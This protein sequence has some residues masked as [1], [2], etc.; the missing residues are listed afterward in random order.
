[1]CEICTP[2]AV[3]GISLTRSNN[4]ADPSASVLARR[5]FLISLPSWLSQLPKLQTLLVDDNPFAGQ[6]K[7][8]VK[9][10]ASNV[11]EIIPPVPQIPERFAARQPSTID[12]SIHHRRVSGSG[13]ANLI[14]DTSAAPSTTSLSS[15]AENVMERSYCQSSPSAAGSPDVARSPYGGLS[16]STSTYFSQTSHAEDSTVASPASQ[17]DVAFFDS[18]LNAGQ[19]FWASAAPPAVRSADSIVKDDIETRKALSSVRAPP[20]ETTSR[21]G[22]ADIGTSSKVVRRMRS[23]GTLFG[24][25][26]ESQE[27]IARQIINEPQSD[28]DEDFQPPQPRFAT[29]SGRPRS[30]A[31]TSLVSY[32]TNQLTDYDSSKAGSSTSVA[33]LGTQRSVSDGKAPAQN[34]SGKWG[35]LKK[36]SMSRLRAN[37]SSSTNSARP[38]APAHSLSES[39]TDSM[40]M[41]PRMGHASYSTGTLSTLGAE[42]PTGR[43]LYGGVGRNQHPGRSNLRLQTTLT[44]VQ[45][46]PPHPTVRG[47][48]QSFLPIWDPPPALNIPIPSTSPFMSS[49]PI[50][51][52]E[53]RGQQLD[54]SST[55]EILASADQMRNS[56][57]VIGS[58]EFGRA[59]PAPQRTVPYDVGLR[60]IM[61]YLRDLYDLSLPVPAAIGGAEVVAAEAGTGSGSVSAGSDVRAESPSPMVGQ[62]GRYNTFVPS[63]RSKK[64][65]FGGSE[66]PRE[67]SENSMAPASG[68][69]PANTAITKMEEE[70]D[71]GTVERPHSLPKYVNVEVESG[72]K[73][74][75]DAGKRAGVVR[76]IVECVVGLEKLILQQLTVDIRD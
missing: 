39:G 38:S 20:R 67:V 69:G 21:L 75:D 35:F 7:D 64:T 26:N 53:P 10:I 70:E 60:S 57:E 73:Y 14:Y 51:S 59:Q 47:K 8:L 74:K 28:A 66:T 37:S 49:V 23:A 31:G 12:P 61:S 41:R 40:V 34:K 56:N 32:S 44:T 1:M 72:K 18:N 65:T 42:T 45:A 3:S 36:M 2:C 19:P 30:R 71:D 6:W 68:S 52:S 25:R 24:F 76:H 43:D 5:N 9:N 63:L 11:V 33:S 54:E 46:S 62:K 48:R 15:Q 29:F 27:Q 58:K 55:Q 13:R 16:S 17:S 22:R 50:M 4:Q